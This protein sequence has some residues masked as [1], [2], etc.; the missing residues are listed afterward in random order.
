MSDNKYK[1]KKV[2]SNLWI[3]PCITLSA[4]NVYDPL[5]KPGKD[6]ILVKKLQTRQTWTENEDIILK[7]LVLEHGAKNWNFIADLLNQKAHEE[8]PIRKAKQCRERWTSSLDPS[9]NKEP[10]TEREDECLYKA[11]AELGNKWSKI[12]ERL[13]TKR[14][15][16]QVK[17]RFNHL[18]KQKFCKDES[19]VWKNY[20]K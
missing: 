17:N 2:S 13:E 18:K 19:G 5:Y 4:Q 10:W 16:N 12:M 20:G 7:E 6:E 1:P 3:V 9:I 14:T 15:E 11:H 8:F